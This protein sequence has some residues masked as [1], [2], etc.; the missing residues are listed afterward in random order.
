MAKKIAAQRKA[1]ETAVCSA[2]PVSREIEAVHPI[3][4]NRTGL[5]GST[6]AGKS[7]E[8][9]VDASADRSF[10]GR[11][12]VGISGAGNTQSIGAAGLNATEKVVM[13]VE[14]ADAVLKES[15]ANLRADLMCVYGPKSKAPLGDAGAVSFL[16]NE[17]EGRCAVR[18]ARLEVLIQDAWRC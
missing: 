3:D 6:R 13:R 4:K 11:T 2:G 10:F 18:R 5:L 14:Q 9:D 7:T 12:S 1:A 15:Y 8:Q 16:L 17:V